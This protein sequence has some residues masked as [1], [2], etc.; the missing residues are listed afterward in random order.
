MLQKTIM[1]TKNTMLDCVHAR[2]ARSTTSRT[3][4]FRHDDDAD[5]AENITRY[6]AVKNNLAKCK[7]GY[8]HTCV[9]R[10][11]C[12]ACAHRTGYTNDGMTKE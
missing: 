9:C 1:F 8:L 6:N 12:D 10:G 5:G 3:K 4:S 2:C 11:E 7:H